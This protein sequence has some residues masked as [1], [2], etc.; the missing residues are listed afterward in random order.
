MLKIVKG[1]QKV[2]ILECTVEIFLSTFDSIVIC[3]LFLTSVES[4]TRIHL[5]EHIMSAVER[6]LRDHSKPFHY[7]GFLLGNEGTFLFLI[8]FS[9]PADMLSD[10]AIARSSGV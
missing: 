1:N 2:N 10:L 5:F 7:E 6:G 4:N 3:F 8:F 9:S